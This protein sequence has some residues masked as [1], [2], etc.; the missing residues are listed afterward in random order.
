MPSQSQSQSQKSTVDEAEVAKFS[1]MAEHWWDPD[2]PLAP[3]HKMGPVRLQFIRDALIAHFA[4]DGEVREPL[5]G[6]SILD[7]GCGGGLIAEPLARLGADVTGIDPS[8]ENIAAAKAHAAQS[9]LDIE[10]RVGAVD[11]V[12]SGPGTEAG[13]F[14]AVMALEMIEH[15]ADPAAAIQAAANLIKPGGAFI[16]STLNRT[17][18]AFALAV[19]GAEYILRWLPRGTHDWTKFQK[20]GEIERMARQAG[21]EITEVKGMTFEPFTGQWRLSDDASVNYIVIGKR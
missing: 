3:L 17:A 18:K 5:K 7:A 10:Y 20:P 6:L 1:A 16:L 4:L 9:R 11:D 14:D 8:P 19:V 21:I 15:V 13:T 2:G 12:G